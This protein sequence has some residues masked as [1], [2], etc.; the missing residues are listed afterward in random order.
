MTV[1]TPVRYKEC[2]SVV[3][4]KLH[5]TKRQQNQSLSYL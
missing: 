5:E 4:F 2:S 3:H 1:V